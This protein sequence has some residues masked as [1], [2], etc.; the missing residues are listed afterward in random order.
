MHVR[1]CVCAYKPASFACYLDSASPGNERES[2]HSPRHLVQV[3][4]ISRGFQ[5]REFVCFCSTMFSGMWSLCGVVCVI[6][7]VSGG[8]INRQSIVFYEHT[9]EVFYCP[10]E[11]PISLQG[12]LK[13]RSS[14]TFIFFHLCSMTENDRVFQGYK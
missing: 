6:G 9:P 8:D 4:A 3:S 14:Y 13:K 10:Q 12:K 11:K 1:T 5:F 2:R 7:L